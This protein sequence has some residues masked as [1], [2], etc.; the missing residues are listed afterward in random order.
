M[1]KRVIWKPNSDPQRNFLASSARIALIG[2]GAGGGKT[3]ALLMAGARQIKN[4]Y[5]RAVIFRQDFPSLR[6]IISKSV[7]LFPQLGGDYNKSEHIWEFPS[8]ATILFSHLENELAVAQHSGQ[9]YSFIG[10]DELQQLPGDTTDSEGQPVNDAFAFMQSRLRAPV[11]SGLDL[12]I[13]AT[14]TPDGPGIAWMKSFFKIP[15]SGKSTEFVDKT[16]GFR[17]AYFRSVCDDNPALDPA[18]KRQ[19]LA[20]PI[21]RKKALLDGDFTA[22]IGQVFTEWNYEL[23]TCD[24]FKVPEG[25]SM[26][27]GGDDGYASPACILWFLYDEIRDRIFIVDEIYQRGLMAEELGEAILTID[28]KYSS[29]PLDGEIDPASFA[30][31]GL[32]SESGSGGRADKMNALGCRWR[33]AQKGAGSRIAGKHLVHS[34]FAL[35][36]DGFPGLVIC[37]NC[38]NL[39]REIPQLCYS[40]TGNTEDVDTNC[41]DHGFD[42]MRYGL[43]RKKFN[44]GRVKLHGL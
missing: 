5:H 37:R 8:G 7:L 24:P 33:A 40:K 32:G 12:F 42:A 16:T 43:G 31:I 18:Y 13:R 6:Q 23:H 1:E 39:I 20:L 22:S 38:K 27:R 11:D 34:R 14:G 3:S 35:K 41:S 36:K 29:E 10:Y 30:D 17:R 28:A 21:Q 44:Y 26:W 15:D 4:R 2:G 25:L 19:L 9:E